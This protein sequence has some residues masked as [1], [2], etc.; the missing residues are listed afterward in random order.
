MSRFIFTSTPISGVYVIESKPIEDSRGYYERYF[1][2]EDFKEI[3]LKKPIVQINH[4]KT[5]I[6]GCIRGFHYQNYPFSEV[7]VIRCIKGAIYDVAVDL[8]KNSPT[9]LKHFGVELSEF[10]SKYLYI[11]E[12]CG[13]AFQTLTEESELLYPVTEFYHPDS[14]GSLNPFDE[15]IGVCWPLEP[16]GLSDKDQN[17]PYVDSYFKGLEN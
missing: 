9:F 16:K 4:S 11:P 1:C 8:R 5:F 14:E 3:G 6:K 2:V 10:N 17:A 12:G 7:K 13:H 15:T